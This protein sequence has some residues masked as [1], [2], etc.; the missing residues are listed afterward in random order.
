MTESLKALTAKNAT[1]G[2]KVENPKGNGLDK[3]G[4][5]RKSM[6]LALSRKE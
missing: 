2:A 6:S 5:N 1:L 3:F 4:G